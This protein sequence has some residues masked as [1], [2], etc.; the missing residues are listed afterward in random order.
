MKFLSGGILATLL[1][2][3]AGGVVVGALRSGAALAIDALSFIVS[4]LSL[5]LIHGR[6]Q[7]AAEQLR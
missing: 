6:P 2:S 3:G 4:A 7:H 1:G 5:A